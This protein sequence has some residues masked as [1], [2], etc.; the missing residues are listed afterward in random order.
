M[1]EEIDMKITLD[2]FCK[3]V[4]EDAKKELIDFIKTLKDL[5]PEEVEEIKRYLSQ[6][7]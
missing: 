4:T 3:K 2:S 6:K 7:N 1:C 5:S